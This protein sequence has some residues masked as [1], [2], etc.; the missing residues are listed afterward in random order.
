MKQWLVGA[1]VLV[2]ASA[3]GG[4]EEGLAVQQQGLGGSGGGL[5]AF[6]QQTGGG[7]G[8]GG[9]SGGMGPGYSGATDTTLEEDQPTTNF[10]ASG[11]CTADGWGDRRNCLL[12]WS[13]LTVPA[14][15]TV[16]EAWIDLFLDDGTA[17]TF[18]VFKVTRAWNEGQATWLNAQSGTPWAGPGATGASDTDAPVLGT[19]TGSVGWRR[20]SLNAAGIA[21]VQD[22]VS[23]SASNKGVVL[24]GNSSDGVHIRSSE[25]SDAAKRPVLFIRYAP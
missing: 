13:S 8:G 19:L 3:C 21:A 5:I 24:G 18:N 2:S 22:W 9:G 15:A 20:I 7:T 16:L 23:N 6:F 11:T 12:Q 10:G 25:Y 1:T 14:S 17:S 4:G